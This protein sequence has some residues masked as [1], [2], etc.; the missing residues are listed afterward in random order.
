MDRV[1]IAIDL[2]S[3]YA[4]V[5]CVD[6]GLDPL[7]TNLVVADAERTDKTICLAVS[8]GLKSYG[9]PGR[10]RLFEVIAKVRDINAERR[11]R[12]PGRRFIGKSIY[13]EELNLNPSLELSYICAVPRMALY[14][15]Y[16]TEVYRI[17]LKY[18]APEDILVYSCDE[19]F[20][21]V[22]TYLNLY[23]C[24]AHELAMRMIRDVLGKT[25]ITATAGIGTNMFLCK[26]AMDIV[27]KKM[28]ADSDGVRIAELDERSFREKLWGHRP[29]T[30]FWRV[31]GGTARRLERLG[32]YTMGDIAGFSEICENNLYKTFGINAELLIDHA[33]GWEPCTIDC[34]KEYKPVTN[35]ISSGQVL[36]RPYSY[37]ETAVIVR[38]MIEL[39][40]LDLVKKDVV[41]SKLTLTIGYE[42]LKDPEDIR[43]YIGELGIDMYGRPT[44]KHSHGTVNLFYKT[45]STKL[46]SQAVMYLYEMIANP[47]LKVRRVN[48]TA[49]DIVPEKD[50]YGKKE[51]EQLSLFVDYDELER[52][53]AAEENARKKEKA[54]QLATL[55]LK[56]RYGKN[57]ILKGTNFLEGATTIVR[58]NQIGG[59]RA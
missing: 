41:T 18:I 56:Q 10:P 6:R 45:S 2:K 34:V 23:K 1:Y 46:L 11:F 26:V 8:P 32:L 27:A 19:V 30:D 24:S 12:A 17:Y 48:I 31:G 14:M 4:S 20:M 22:S 59:H 28:P 16:S 44:P 38:E 5:E 53:R 58:N 42:S 13:T 29:I 3:F 49:C 50:I 57:A 35:S 7:T 52:K 33:W 43:K 15:K 39:L 40:T 47:D 51:Y 54:L 9:V 25:G 36:T 55:S 37:S 21:D